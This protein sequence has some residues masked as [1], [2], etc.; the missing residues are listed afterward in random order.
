VS[1]QSNRYAY[2]KV[3]VRVFADHPVAGVGS[4]G[5]AVEWLKRRPFAEGVRDAHSLYLETLAELGL[6]GAAC[7]AVLIAGVVLACRGGP[8]AAVAGVVAFGLHAGLDWDWE[9]PALSLC[10]LLLVARLAALRER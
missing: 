4:G 3:A 9:M 7:L 1:V 10:A 2:W 8:P 5:F 6:V